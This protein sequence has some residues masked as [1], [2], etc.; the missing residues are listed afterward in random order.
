MC[1][2]TTYD[3]S[4]SFVQSEETNWVSKAAR[5]DREKKTL[6]G[7]KPRADPHCRGPSSVFVVSY[8]TGIYNWE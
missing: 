6:C 8:L 3:V 1:Q 2:V 4:Q 5:N 7:K